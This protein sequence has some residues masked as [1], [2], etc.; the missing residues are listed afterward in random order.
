MNNSLNVSHT[1]YM[2]QALALAQI[3]RGFCAP[4][5]AVGAVVV[6]GD[7]VIAEGYH[8]AP[9]Q[10]HAEV[11]ALAKLS[12]EQSRDAIVYVTLEPCCHQGRTP[13]CVDLLIQKGVK[14]VYYGFRD[15]NPLVAGQGAKQLQ[16]AGVTCQF[17]PLPEVTAF[18]QSYAYW[19]Q[20]RRPWVTAK[21]ALSL[22][23]K[24]AGA[25]G[26]PVAITGPEL[27]Q[28]THQCRK[29]SDAILTT[30]A[31]VLCDNPQLNVR[32]AGE[33]ISKPVYILDSRLRFPMDAQL[34][35]TAASI[36]LL[37][38]DDGN[39][40]LK[41]SLSTH[42]I[43]CV[44]IPAKHGK[45]SLQA[46]LEYIGQDGVHDLWVEAGGT[47]FQALLS[48]GLVHRALIYQSLKWLGEAA[49][50]AFTGQFDA[51][52]KAQ[53]MTRYSVGNDVVSDLSF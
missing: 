45:I 7:E 3:R 49:Q 10:P 23:G 26:E 47:C 39:N 28:Y 40:T 21:I 32:L 5:P 31:T 35:S 53:T 18:Y 51:L 44:P 19:H 48:E 11:N 4:N 43:R 14:A 1:Q 15:P 50:P 22:D 6:K 29:K 8:M 20:Y 52:Q 37:Y 34:L 12:D 41:N 36:T 13:P 2:M 30:I 42:S 38:L 24:I 27:Q 9:G 25:N 16:A 17:L 46:V 33:T